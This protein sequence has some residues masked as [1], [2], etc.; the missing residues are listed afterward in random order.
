MWYYKIVKV[1]KNLYTPLERGESAARAGGNYE[2][3]L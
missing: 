1:K 2:N 3:G